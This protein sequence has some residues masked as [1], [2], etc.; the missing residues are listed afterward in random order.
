DVDLDTAWE[1]AHG[2]ER[3]LAGDR[4]GLAALHAERRG[5]Y[6]GLADVIMTSAD[7][8]FRALRALHSLAAAPP[9]TRL[10]WAGAASGEYPVLIGSG[11]LAGG[12][13]A[14]GGWAPHPDV[15]PALLV[16]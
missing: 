12:G 13:R 8:A 15:S 7:A 4:D 5:L 16:R 3:P 6:A 9:G 1:R 11:L 10:L 14:Q 2:K